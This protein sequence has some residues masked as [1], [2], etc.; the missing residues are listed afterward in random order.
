MSRDANGNIIYEE[1]ASTESS[2]NIDYLLQK[3]IHVNYHPVYWFN[4]FMPKHS[5]RQS[6]PDEVSI[7]DLASCTKNKLVVYPNCVPFTVDEVMKH[8]GL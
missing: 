7:A 5:K 2:F 1:V 8:I 6:H 3:K 4:V